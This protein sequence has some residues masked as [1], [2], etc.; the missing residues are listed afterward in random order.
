MQQKNREKGKVLQFDP[1][2]RNKLKNVDYV[3]PAQKELRK[4]RE[5]VIRNTAIFLGLVVTAYL[6]KSIL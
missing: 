2:R 4:K 6:I 5:K 3:D 1:G